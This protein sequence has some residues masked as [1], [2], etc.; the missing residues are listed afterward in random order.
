MTIDEEL[1]IILEFAEDKPN[2]LVR[3]NKTLLS[4][5]DTQKKKFSYA[6]TQHVEVLRRKLVN[7][8]KKYSKNQ[9]HFLT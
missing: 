8:R 4:Y 6:S 3:S 1:E 5:S 2:S 9:K 7:G